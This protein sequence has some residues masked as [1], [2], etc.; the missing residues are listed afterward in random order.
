MSITVEKEA[1]LNKQTTLVKNFLP[2]WTGASVLIGAVAGS[3]LP[4]LAKNNHENSTRILRPG[5]PNK[6]KVPY[7]LSLG[8]IVGSVAGTIAGV[9][10]SERAKAH[11]KKTVPDWEKADDQQLL[12]E[13][14][15]YSPMNETR[16]DSVSYSMQGGALKGA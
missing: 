12:S 11:L 8:A 6:F 7:L 15:A 3:F 1:A 16:Q 9:I 14:N 4:L 2:K 10:Q 13:A 5:L